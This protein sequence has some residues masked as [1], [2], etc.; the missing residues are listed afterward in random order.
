[1]P[2]TVIQG[3]PMDP[4]PFEIV[5]R[6]RRCLHPHDTY[7]I[8]VKTGKKEAGRDRSSSIDGRRRN[9]RRGARPNQFPR[10]DPRADEKNRSRDTSNAARP[11]KNHVE[12][13]D[14]SRLDG[15]SGGLQL[16]LVGPERRA[17][18]LSSPHPSA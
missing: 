13:D 11:T 2:P 16:A 5:I 8:V 12:R 15:G 1:M 4:D 6:E 3:N 7:L 10:R 18:P 17:A 9:C 14:R